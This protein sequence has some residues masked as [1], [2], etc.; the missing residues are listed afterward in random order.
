VRAALVLGA[1]PR[2]PAK[3]LH[4]PGQPVARS[5]ELLQAEQ[6]WAGEDLL[7]GIRRG[8]EGK[9]LGDDRR[10]LALEPRDLRPQRAPRRA[11]AVAS[12]VRGGRGGDLRSSSSS[13]RLGDRLADRSSAVDDW[14]LGL[15]HAQLLLLAP[16]RGFY[17]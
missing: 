15:G 5:L 14:L 3:L 13:G 10:E 17:Q 8:D 9:P 12:T 2:E 16:G 1:L 7:R 11:L 4:T 6:A